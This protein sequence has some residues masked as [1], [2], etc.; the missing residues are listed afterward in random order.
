MWTKYLNIEG[1]SS[2]DDASCLEKALERF[3]GV[4]LNVFYK[5]RLCVLE[6]S[7]DVSLET[8]KGCIEDKGY[9]VEVIDNKA[10]KESMDP[11]FFPFVLCVIT[12][13][14]ILIFI[15]LGGTGALMS[16]M[17]ASPIYFLGLMLIIVGIVF[18]LIGSRSK[19]L[20]RGHKGGTLK[21]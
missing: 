7:S 17:T 19:R 21:A 16:M 12:C 2:P 9:K 11:S 5:E 18:Y 13:P 14:L 1:M 3:E 20:N 6:V 8:L 15:S 4:E 10:T